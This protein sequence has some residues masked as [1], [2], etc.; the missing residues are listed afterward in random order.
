MQPAEN[1]EQEAQ[2]RS[3]YNHGATLFETADYDGAIEAFTQALKIANTYGADPQVR[4]A[5]LYNIGKSRMKAYEV[6]RDASELRQALAIYTRFVDD[7]KAGAGYTEKDVADAEVE[8]ASI[9]AKLA[10]I[11]AA[12]RATPSPQ[13]AKTESTTPPVKTSSTPPAEADTDG[14]RPRKIALTWTIMGG[15]GLVGGAALFAYGTTFDNHAADQID[16]EAGMHVDEADYNT[17]QREFYGGEVNRGYAVMGSGIGLAAL[18]VAAL[19][20]GIIKLRRTRPGQD[21]AQL[22]LTPMGLRGVA[23]VG[24]F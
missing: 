13:P 19:T 22:T 18:G 10:E 20:V 14:A 17:A 21:T 3:L 16:N 8:I 24:R 5:L 15:A 9:R 7:A 23:L 6:S 11:D 12:T 4:G 2:V 1:A